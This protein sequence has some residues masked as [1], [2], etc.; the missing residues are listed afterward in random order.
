MKGWSHGHSSIIHSISSPICHTSRYVSWYAFSLSHI[1]AYM[2]LIDSKSDTSHSISVTDSM[3]SSHGDI[4][5]KVVVILS[6]SSRILRYEL[7]SFGW[8]KTTR[9][10]RVRFLVHSHQRLIIFWVINSLSILVNFISN[11]VCIGYFVSFIKWRLFL[12]TQSNFQAMYFFIYF[13][14]FIVNIYNIYFS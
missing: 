10:M 5:L 12:T 7:V 9:R 4:D 14:W 6:H 8:A 13:P 1:V 3:S 2:F 11:S